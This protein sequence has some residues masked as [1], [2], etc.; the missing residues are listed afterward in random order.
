[1]VDYLVRINRC[2]LITALL[3]QQD[4]H[5][6]VFSSLLYA[7]R[8]VT[9]SGESSEQPTRLKM[10]FHVLSIIRACGLYFQ[11]CSELA[12]GLYS[13]HKHVTEFFVE[14]HCLSNTQ[15]I[16]CLWLQLHIAHLLE[17][18]Y[19]G[20]MNDEE[21]GKLVKP[22]LLS[23]SKFVRSTEDNKASTDFGGNVKRTIQVFLTFGQLHIDK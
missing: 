13:S 9:P 11:Y 18:V 4:V 12:S 20:Y 21:E 14:A 17:S 1:M 10:I 16:E 6:V 2:V 15:Q 22:A 23:E 19:N 5:P 8:K 7:L 3:E